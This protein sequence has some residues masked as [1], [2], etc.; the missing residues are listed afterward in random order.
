MQ[1]QNRKDVEWCF[2]V[3]QAHIAIIQNPNKQWDMATIKSIRVCDF[4]Q[5]DHRRW[6]QF[7]T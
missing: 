4:V 5:Y 6:I 2:R 1:Q 3:L 7:A